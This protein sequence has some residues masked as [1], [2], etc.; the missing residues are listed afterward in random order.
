MQLS[1]LEIRSSFSTSITLYCSTCS[2]QIYQKFNNYINFLIQPVPFI[3]EGYYHLNQ[4]LIFN[5]NNGNYQKCIHHSKNPPI[6][7]HFIIF[8]KLEIVIYKDFTQ[9]VYCIIYSV[10]FAISTF[11]ISISIIKS[12]LIMYYS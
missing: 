10:Y 11:N 4:Y 3:I 7:V 1:S 2:F 6:G 9:I 5:T 12:L 8:K